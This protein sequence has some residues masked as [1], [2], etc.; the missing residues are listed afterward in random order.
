MVSREERLEHLKRFYSLLDVLKDRPGGVRHLSECD[1]RGM[2]WP[3]RG[4]YFFMESSE[5]RTDSGKG[6]RIVRVGTHALEEGSK[7]K[8]WNR[9]RQ[10]RGSVKSNGGN[11]RGSIFRSLVGSALIKRDGHKCT[12]WEKSTAPSDAQ[13]QEKEQYLEEEVSKEIR[14]MPFLWLTV[15]DEPGPCSLRGRIE[16]NA[17]ALLSNYCEEKPIDPPS[18]SWLGRHCERKKVQTSKKV[19]NSGLWNSNHVGE[20][21]NPAFLDELKSLVYK[22]PKPK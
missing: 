19:K 21:Y 17:I 8:L 13:K 5:K 2:W 22:V 6:Q 1:G 20:V 12:S 9:L 3:P 7:S 10:H 4:V 18:S 15:K 11:H 14:K 16:R